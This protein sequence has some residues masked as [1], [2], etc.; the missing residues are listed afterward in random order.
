MFQYFFCRFHRQ[1]VVLH[2]KDYSR[3]SDFSP[4]VAVYIHASQRLSHL[5]PTLLE[6]ADLKLA[7]QEDAKNYHAWTHRQWVVRTFDLWDGEL[8]FIDGRCCT[9]HLEKHR[10]DCST[11]LK[12]PG[13]D[14][15]KSVQLTLSVLTLKEYD[16]VDRIS[17][18]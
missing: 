1:R 9:Q 8:E 12:L 14:F 16:D 13:L 11:Q 7:F 5:L 3:G 6:K 4:S 15:D 2:L 17:R 18:P 10:T